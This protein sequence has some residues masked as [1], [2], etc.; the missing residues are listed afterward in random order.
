MWSPGQTAAGARLSW[1]LTANPARRHSTMP[2]NAA[3]AVLPP[4]DLIGAMCYATGLLRRVG[5]VE[6]LKR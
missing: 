5:Q 1:P 6:L 2:A 4:A 3:S